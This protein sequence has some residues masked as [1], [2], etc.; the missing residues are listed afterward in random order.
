M[1]FPF[2]KVWRV[3]ATLLTG[4]LLWSFLCRALQVTL[5]LSSDTISPIWVC[6]LG[7]LVLVVIV[8][9]ARGKFKYDA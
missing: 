9:I 2:K 7:I 3:V 4:G 1:S 5:R 6:G 8:Q